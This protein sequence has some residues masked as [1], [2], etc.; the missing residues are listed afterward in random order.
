MAR[1]IYTKIFQSEV[2]DPASFKSGFIPAL[3]ATAAMKAGASGEAIDV[4]GLADAILFSLRV[5]LS[6][7]CT[8]YY[9]V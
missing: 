5:S 1:V 9:P 3:Q 6:T 4:L 8:A 7:D 2:P